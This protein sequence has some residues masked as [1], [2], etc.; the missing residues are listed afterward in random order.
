[1]ESSLRMALKEA[2][3]QIGQGWKLYQSK[4]TQGAIRAFE[5]VITDLSRIADDHEKTINLVDAYYGLGLAVRAT[6]NTPEA[7][8]AFAQALEM[9]E[10][11]LKALRGGDIENNLD[12]SEDDRYAMLITMIKQRMSEMGIKVNS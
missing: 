12:T 6:G 11:N 10:A 3:R 9:C 5:S 2:T 1:M 8:K 7:T 4:D